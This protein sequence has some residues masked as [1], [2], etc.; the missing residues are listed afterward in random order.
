M[1]LLCT[2][3]KYGF[4]TKQPDVEQLD[5]TEAAPCQEMNVPLWRHSTRVVPD[6]A[7]TLTQEGELLL[8]F[9]KPP[10]PPPPPTQGGPLHQYKCPGILKITVP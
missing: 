4:V 8:H 9:L 2:I 5:L 10:I 6:E 1:L 7:A 3:M